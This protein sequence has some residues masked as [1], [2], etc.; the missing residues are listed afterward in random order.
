DWVHAT[1]EIRLPDGSVET[2]AVPADVADTY[3]AEL[4]DFLEAIAD[5]RPPT[6][7][8]DEGVATVEL[9]D[10]LLASSREGRRITLPRSP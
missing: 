5:Q 9:A 4:R 1:I 8:A 10:A 7:C 2:I 3:V 6:I